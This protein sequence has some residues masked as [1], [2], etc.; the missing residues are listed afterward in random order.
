MSRVFLAKLH[1]QILTKSGKERKEQM[2]RRLMPYQN[3]KARGKNDKL[4]SVLGNL[5]KFAGNNL[6]FD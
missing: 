1:K 3:R 4:H 5:E 6:F 2:K